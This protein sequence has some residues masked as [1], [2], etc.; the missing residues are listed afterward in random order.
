MILYRVIASA[1][2]P[3]SSVIWFSSRET[4]AEAVKQLPDAEMDAV[5]VPTDA[6]GLAA[7]LNARVV[8]KVWPR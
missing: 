1:K 5:D 6:A 8:S 2:S 3:K 7:W 4:A